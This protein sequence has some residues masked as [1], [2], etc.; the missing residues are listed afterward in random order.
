MC[1][2]QWTG[3]SSRRLNALYAIKCCICPKDL[4]QGKLRV[5][6]KSI[7][8]L[9][10]FLIAVVL[11]MTILFAVLIRA[12]ALFFAGTAHLLFLKTLTR[13]SV[14]PHVHAVCRR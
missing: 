12:R 9:N 11:P 3:V 6:M 1:L 5:A 10:L 7:K 8:L 13:F 4:Q 2:P 14:L